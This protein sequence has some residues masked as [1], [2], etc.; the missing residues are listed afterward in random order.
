MTSLEFVETM[1]APIV[2]KI[3]SSTLDHAT[4]SVEV[5]PDE[6]AEVG[7]FEVV[8]NRIVVENLQQTFDAEDRLADGFD[9]A[10]FAL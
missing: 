7:T 10:V 3:T 9:E 5:D 8:R 4:R 1:R 2:R 6:E